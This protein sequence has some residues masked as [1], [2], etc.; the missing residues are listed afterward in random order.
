MPPPAPAKPAAVAKAKAAA[1]KR[2]TTSDDNNTS[3][4]GNAAGGVSKHSAALAAHA[5]FPPVSSDIYGTPMIDLDKASHWIY[6]STKEEG[7][8]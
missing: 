7:K 8:R 3:E 1:R 5:V 6:P 2:K 4:A